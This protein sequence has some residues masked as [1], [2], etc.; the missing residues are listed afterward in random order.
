MARRFTNIS[1]QI[2]SIKD[3]DFIKVSINDFE[4]TLSSLGASIF[5][6]K[7]SNQYMTCN[8]SENDFVKSNHYFGK[9]VGRVANRIS[10]DLLIDG[11]KYHFENNEGDTVLH[12]GL[13]GVSF[14]NFDYKINEDNQQ[15]TVIFTYLSKDLES[16]FPGNIL[17][18]VTYI[19]KQNSINILY[20]AT[21]DKNTIFSTTNHSFYCLGEQNLDNL[22][23]F[24]NASRFIHP[25]EKDL[26]PVEARDVDQL[27]DFRKIKKFSNSLDVGYLKNSRTNGIDHFYIFDCIVLNEPQIILKSTKY[28]LSINTDFEGT[29]VYS[30]NYP[31]DFLC[32]NSLEKIHRGIAIEPSARID[33]IHYLAKDEKY[34]HEITLSFDIL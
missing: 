17:F 28:Q 10:N 27:M 8:P 34:H 23:L 5:S 29:Q 18:K 30:D 9:T 20:D 2:Y 16:G 13:N 6:I 1:F 25:N 7:L 19:I 33:E 22:S 32:L 3:Y 15:M 21:S 14:K 31:N 24:I 26:S 4:V 12:G 11:V